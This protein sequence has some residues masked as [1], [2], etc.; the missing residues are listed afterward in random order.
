MISNPNAAN[1]EFDINTFNIVK[2]LESKYP[3]EIAE[4]LTVIGKCKDKESE[5]YTNAVKTIDTKIGNLESN[6]HIEID[7]E[8]IEDRSKALSFIGI[9]VADALKGIPTPVE[10]EIVEEVPAMEEQQQYISD[11]TFEVRPS[12]WQR[13]KQS[14]IVRTMSY[15]FKIKVRLELPDALPE[16]RG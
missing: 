11:T 16:G 9:E 1:N 8:R 13:I 4:A 12:L 2:K 7:M 14:R 3:A 5:D 15:I 10:E 6:L